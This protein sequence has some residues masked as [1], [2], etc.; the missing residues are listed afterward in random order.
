M[1]AAIMIDRCEK[2]HRAENLSSCSYFAFCA[3]AAA[4]A[5]AA[6]MF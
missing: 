2:S 1:R 6:M 5:A 3:Y 4:A